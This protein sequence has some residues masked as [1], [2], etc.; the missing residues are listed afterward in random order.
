MKGFEQW[1]I[2]YMGS[3][4]HFIIPV[5]QRNYDWKKEQCQQLYDDLLSVV[6]RNVSSHF[7]GSIVS[8]SDPDGKMLDY[9]IIDGQQRLITVSLLM[10][11]MYRLLMEGKVHAE[12]ENLALMLLK[13]YLIDE[14]EDDHQKIKL[15]PI[16]DDQ[17]AFTSLFDADGE[18]VADSNLT[19]NYS[20]F[21]QRIQRQEVSIDDLYAAIC[22][23]QVINITLSHEDDPQLIF[24]SLNSTGLALSEG[25][26][27][28]NYILMGL[29]IHDQEA[30]YSKYWNEI[31]KST[32]FDVSSFVRDYLTIKQQAIPSIKNIYA[33]FKQYRQKSQDLT[34]EDVLKDML[35]YAKRYH[36][37]IQPDVTSPAASELD[38]CIYRLNRLKT[39]VTRPFFL[40]VLRLRDEQK[41]AASDLLN[42]FLQTEAYLFR[43][44]ICDLSTNS[45]NQIFLFLHRDIINLDSSEENYNDKLTYVLGSKRES[46]RFPSDEEFCA[47]LSRKNVYLMRSEAKKYLFERL[48]NGWLKDGAIGVWS[49]LDNGSLSIEHIM[50]QTLTRGWIED[51]GEDHERIYEQWLHRLANLTL[52]GYN[53]EY[54]NY[55]FPEKKSMTGGF[56]EG[57]LH[58]NRWIK[59]QDKWT[60]AELEQ[61]DAML[62][63]EARKLWPRRDTTYCPPE[64]PMNRVTLEE[65][66]AL[67]GKS[68]FRYAFHGVEQAV[69]SW[70]ELYQQVLA[71]LHERD[72]SVLTHLAV[73]TDPSEDMTAHFSTVPSSLYPCR[74]I[75]EGIYA[76]TG[77]STMSKISLLKR[78]FP[79]FEEDPNNLVFYLDEA[80][81][82]EDTGK[83]RH[84]IRKKYWQYAMSS[85]RQA[86]GTFT[87]S[88]DTTSNT[89]AGL[90]SL[91][92]VQLLCIA[93][94]DSAK[95]KLYIDR[96]DKSE[97]K[98]LFDFLFARKEEIE[99][100]YGGALTWDRSEETR[101][102]SLED[103]LEGVSIS[104]EA[105]WP[106][107][108]QFHAVQAAALL[109][110]I[111]NHLKEFQ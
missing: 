38:W 21:Y 100:A 59:Q 50:P 84:T 32:G 67:T 9:L 28:R 105:D 18:P 60:E 80:D 77:T 12:Q 35:T 34:T 39:T 23:L 99:T 53:S 79:L 89:V 3:G 110:S 14:F 27:I 25:D 26:K 5:Y 71:Q 65:D 51:L 49:K 101:S 43:R 96:K 56:E 36:K 97:N 33:S 64:R 93:N 76:L 8:V 63:Q 7:F 102:S 37:L 73:S 13:K 22:K 6:R 2:Q 44:S 70:A 82:G 95:V 86:T 47:A 20:Y 11:A 103:R 72:K 19:H 81:E 90:T 52:T 78:I 17:K 108:A 111:E 48:E 66:E 42:I 31:E 30:Y 54:K 85:I 41:L 104:Q 92:G 10:L 45:L 15:K 29:S 106:R 75:D 55:R 58:I 16:K 109:K 40:E 94:Y 69:T 62:Q 57:G 61:R 46:A 88:G 74:K 87:Y 24:E 68:I 1:L 91:P 107:M 83:A 98:R 4:A